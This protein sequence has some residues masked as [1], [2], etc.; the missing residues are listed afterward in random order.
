MATPRMTCFT[1]TGWRHAVVALVLALHLVSHVILETTAAQVPGVFATGTGTV[2]A[3][4]STGTI[5]FSAGLD[6][7][8]PC[9]VTRPACITVCAPAANEITTGIKIQIKGSSLTAVDTNEWPALSANTNCKAF[10]ACSIYSALQKTDCGNLGSTPVQ[11]EVTLAAAAGSEAVPL[12]GVLASDGSEKAKSEYLVTAFGGASPACTVADPNQVIA[13]KASVSEDGEVPQCGTE[14]DNSVWTV[15]TV[16]TDVFNTLADEDSFKITNGIELSC[17]D[18]PSPDGSLNSLTTFSAATP[19]AAD[20]GAAFTVAIGSAFSDAATKPDAPYVLTACLKDFK[21]AATL[22]LMVKE[23]GS[24]LQMREIE[25]SADSEDRCFVVT[26]CDL[27]AAMTTANQA[28][29]ETLIFK[30]DKDVATLG[31]ATLNGVFGTAA[32]GSGE[33]EPVVKSN[34]NVGIFVKKDYQACHLKDGKKE[35][36]GIQKDASKPLPS[37]GSTTADGVTG[38]ATFVT[39]KY[40]K[41]EDFTASATPATNTFSCSGVL[42]DLGVNG[43]VS[44]FALAVLAW[45]R[46]RI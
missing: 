16:A 5:S 7:W 31:T 15:K 11:V 29:I 38:L 45:Q 30:V 24:S 40:P 41:T 20:S 26:S 14:G 32:L 36:K 46:R 27:W 1:I 2:A 33:G 44:A 6:Q 37:C 43:V 28:T 10:C 13:K 17:G 34:S 42:R 19:T 22:A 21:Q 9:D 39:N 23:G 12:T 35:E 4:A 3:S 8:D 25:R 18:G